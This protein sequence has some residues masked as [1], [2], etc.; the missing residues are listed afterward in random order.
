MKNW[1]SL[2]LIFS[3]AAAFAQSAPVDRLEFGDPASEQA[4]ALQAQGSVVI[5]GGL[6]RPARQLLPDAEQ[7]W[8]SADMAF[9]IKVDAK[10]QNYATVRLWGGDTTHNKLVL[11]CEGKQIGY[12]HLGDIEILDLGTE[13]PTY[14]G[15]FT[16]KTFPLPLPLTLG[17]SE[18]ACA[19]RALGKFAVYNNQ[20]A[21]FQQPMDGPSR[22]VYALNVHTQPD[23]WFDDAG[24]SAP[25]SPRARTSPGAE[26]ME[27]LKTRIN[28]EIDKQLASQQSPGQDDMFFLARARGMA[29]TTAHGRP[30]DVA[31]RIVAGGDAFYQRYLKDPSFITRDGGGATW[32]AL[33]P[34][35]WALKLTGPELSAA[36]DQTVPGRD[37]QPIKRREAYAEMVSHGMEFLLRNRRMYTNQTLI[38]DLQG[39]YYSNEALRMLGS[40]LAR[41]EPQ[42]RALL[43]EAVGLKPWSGSL[44]EKGRLSN[45]S[46]AADTGGFSVGSGYLQF[47]AA[48]LSKE[49]GFVGSYGEIQDLLANAYLATVPRPGEAGDAQ[50]LAQFRKVSR[51]RQ[52]FRYPNVDLD[53]YRTM[54]LE[55]VIGWR[56]VKYP[57][58]T[59][60][61]QRIGWDN[62][63]LYPALVADDPEL[64]A[65]AQQ[66]VADGQF[67]LQV[68]QQMENKGKRVTH[69]LLDAYEEW[70][71]VTR[72]PRVQKP[73]PMADG[74]P[75][76][77]FVDPEN[78]T[79]AVKHGQ[80][81]LYAALYWR[82]NC[83]INRLSRIHHLTPTL[84]RVA[85]VYGRVEFTPSGQYCTRHNSVQFA[86]GAI[87]NITYPGDVP[88]PLAG[89]LLP[90]AKGPAGAYAPAGRDSPFAGR[91][92]YYETR[93]G[94]YLL[95]INAASPEP[96][97]VLM[98]VIGAKQRLLNLGTGQMLPATQR[99][100]RVAPG[101]GVVVRVVDAP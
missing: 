64:L 62:T 66:M 96:V 73:M 7:R 35:A 28:A 12:R 10:L 74:S 25:P 76:F 34:F 59:T 16:D 95:A 63:P 54:S 42:M 23:A 44:D 31:A 77:V 6:G 81:R 68:Q 5:Q 97:D 58:V 52:Y 38:V 37:G 94:P 101:Q 21:K 53:G 40:A 46:S 48:G 70:Q 18:L 39:I 26:V 27:A 41:P 67:T 86:A 99:S 100:L 51:A 24:A 89:E 92:E 61:V 79:I 91:G 4:H 83:G 11:L 80:E 84:E 13:A 50:L 2:P 19:I 1:L 88:A 60:Y 36:L 3:M 65:A 93:Y 32:I 87:P 14:A 72:A 17:K 90:I 20:F 45:A 33:G 71:H 30:A 98:P 56:D 43:H 15:R 55:T 69:G 75:D 57:G 49:L 22:P 29:W 9:R 85:T 78:A 82:A 8:R 47:T